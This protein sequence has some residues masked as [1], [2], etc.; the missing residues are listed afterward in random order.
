MSSNL[1]Y[2][3]KGRIQ[4]GLKILGSSYNVG[5]LEIIVDNDLITYGEG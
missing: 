5:K 2:R 1:T 4:S 3:N